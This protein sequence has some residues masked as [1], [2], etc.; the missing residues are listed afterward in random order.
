[1]GMVQPQG[2][3]GM[4]QPQGHCAVQGTPLPYGTV[5]ALPPYQPD[6]PPGWQVATDPHSGK[7]YYYNLTTNETSWDLP[8]SSPAPPIQ[9]PP[10]APPPAPRQSPMPPND[11]HLHSHGI[12]PPPPSAVSP[13]PNSTPVTAPVPLAPP[14][15]LVTTAQ[16]AAPVDPR[17][18]GDAEA[19]ID[20]EP[21]IEP[22]LQEIE[23][24]LHL[25]SS[26]S[27]GPTGG[28]DT[29]ESGGPDSPELPETT[30]HPATQP[31][32][33]EQAAEE[34]DTVYPQK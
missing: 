34:A 27:E 32:A 33:I 25:D 29:P 21:E 18:G 22:E 24:E 19:D 7:A 4:V 13:P 11:P 9:P 16:E 3:M 6:L 30:L 8:C 12:S 1:M 10:P 26:A 23:L 17:Q 5:G 2:H 15:P 14:P 31:V 28:P 20:S